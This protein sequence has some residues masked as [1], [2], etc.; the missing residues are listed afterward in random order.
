MEE[1][2]Q[3]KR[4][5]S[6]MTIKVGW[7]GPEEVTRV[8]REEWMTSSDMDKVLSLPLLSLSTYLLRFFFLLLLL[9]L[10]RERRTWAL[11]VTRGV[12]GV[13]V[14]STRKTSFLFLRTLFRHTWFKRVWLESHNWYFFFSVFYFLF[15][16][17]HRIHTWEVCKNWE[18]WFFFLTIF[19]LNLLVENFGALYSLKYNIILTENSLGSVWG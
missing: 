9:L 6:W 10:Q 1:E 15:Y 14:A 5:G 2:R 8:Q 12:Q 13:A 3:T 18:W 4:V 7:W 17:K 11:I 19:L 16:L